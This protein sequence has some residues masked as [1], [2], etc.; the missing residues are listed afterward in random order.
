MDRSAKL[1][2][3]RA[4]GKLYLVLLL[5]VGIRLLWSA[6][7]QREAERRTDRNKSNIKRGNR[8]QAVNGHSSQDYQR[9]WSWARAGEASAVHNSLFQAVN[10]LILAPGLAGLIQGFLSTWWPNEE[11]SVSL[12]PAL[13]LLHPVP[14]EW[15]LFRAED[16]LIKISAGRTML[17]MEQPSQ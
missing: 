5:L 14:V 1:V 2:H 3:D 8:W 17:L 10:S 16:G 4:R 6:K 13:P 11:L 12:P 15:L 9:N 7:K